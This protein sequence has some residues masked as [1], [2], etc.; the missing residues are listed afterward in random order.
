L[1]ILRRNPFKHGKAKLADLGICSLATVFWAAAGIVLC[2]FTD[3][4][5]KAGLP[6][7]SWRN[8]LCVLAWA[9]FLMFAGLS[10]MSLLLVTRRSQK[11]FDKWNAAHVKKQ[12]QK[13]AAKM[14]KLCNEEAERQQAAAAAAA[15]AREQQHS[16]PPVAAAAASSAAA[17]HGPVQQQQ[18]S[19][20]V[21]VA[22]PL[23]QGRAGAAAAVDNSNPFL[24]DNV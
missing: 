18:Q 6:E 9:L 4:A 23:Q 21:A 15:A 12:Q 19:A 16:R 17:A 14:Q 2:L 13:E 3:R 22:A 5:N 8:G 7:S 1:Q 24:A 11:L 20:G 10:I